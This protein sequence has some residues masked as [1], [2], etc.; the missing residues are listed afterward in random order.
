MDLGQWVEHRMAGV[1]RDIPGT[2]PHC[3][4]FAR[5]LQ[6]SSADNLLNANKQVES[7]NK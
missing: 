1:A 2:N 6:R 4:Y 5:H 3:R 7:E